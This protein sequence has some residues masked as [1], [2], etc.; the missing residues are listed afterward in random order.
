[1]EFK[2]Y[3]SLENV[4][5]RLIAIIEE[6][7]Y[8]NVKYAITEKIHGANFGIH[9]DVPTD[10]LEFS[11]RNAFLKDT[12]AFNGYTS[13]FKEFREAIDYIIR[14]YPF[15]KE[16]RIF[17]EI[18][19]GSLNGK[20]GDNAKR[21]AGEVE[22]S[23]N[24][25]FMAFELRLDNVPQPFEVMEEIIRGSGLAVVPL[26]GLA[27]NIYD[28]LAVPNNGNSLVPELLGYESPEVNVKEGNVIVP[29]SKVLYF[30]N[31]SRV[32][33]KNK[34]S[35]FSESK[36]SKLIT[37][38]V[39]LS[40]KGNEVLAAVHSNLTANRL[41]NVLSKE[42]VEELTNKDFG[43]IMGLLMKDALAEY[44]S[45]FADNA[46][47]AAGGEWPQICKAL[48]REAQDITRAY[49]IEYIF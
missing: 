15:V 13:M 46:K 26:L 32:A 14:M 12:E 49:F 39:D 5:Q 45:E 1:M 38:P 29:Y 19:G 35:K 25:E 17:G 4:K 37:K 18:F 48:T 2:K 24:N 27:D 10:L 33:I 41:A 36:I 44:N 21:V 3:H 23:P 6:H 30:G 11:R 40:E 9:Y 43:R 8:A 42:V 22:Y 47:E 31:G 16:I 28:A 7:G 34:N 20:Q